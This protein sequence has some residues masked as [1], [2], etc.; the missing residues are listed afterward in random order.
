MG[1]TGG[2]KDRS[3][4]FRRVRRLPPTN[5]TASAPSQ[6]GAD[7]EVVR[8]H[9]PGLAAVHARLG[10]VEAAHVNAVEPEERQQARVGARPPPRIANPYLAHPPPPLHP[11]AAPPPP[12]L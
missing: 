5:R 7:R 12:P 1:L 8:E 11:H 10:D 2:G 9:R 4:F 3:P 6:L